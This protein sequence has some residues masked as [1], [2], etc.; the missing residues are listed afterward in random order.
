MNA[1]QQQVVRIFA[2]NPVVYR[3]EAEADIEIDLG[4][5]KKKL[6]GPAFIESVVLSEE[7]E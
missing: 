2:G 4:T 7:A 1:A 5:E 3:L 6:T